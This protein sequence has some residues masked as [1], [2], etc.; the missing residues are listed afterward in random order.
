MPA[1]N[2]YTVIVLVGQD[3]SVV[4]SEFT[5]IVISGDPIHNWEKQFSTKRMKY[6]TKTRNY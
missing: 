1:S 2:I 6:S 3:F 5:D 4:E